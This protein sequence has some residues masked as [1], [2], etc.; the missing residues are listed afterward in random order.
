MKRAA[1]LLF[2]SLLLLLVTGF[3]TAVLARPDDTA[4]LEKWTLDD[5][6]KFMISNEQLHTAVVVNSMANHLE[7]TF[8][9]FTTSDPPALAAAK[10]RLATIEQFV[11]RTSAE[12]NIPVPTVYV[13]G[14]ATESAQTLEGQDFILV[15]K[16]K[17]RLAILADA[18]AANLK[19]TLAYQLARIRDR[20]TSASAVLSHHNDPAASREAELRAELE[21]AGPLGAHD[22]IAA[23]ITLDA[24]MRDE[25]HRLVFFKGNTLGD[26]DPNRLSD[27]DYK[28]ISDDYVRF[29]DDIYKLT[30][31]DRI[32]ALRKEAQLVN[33]YEQTH[34]VRRHADR[35][36]ESQWLVEQ[37]VKSMQCQIQRDPTILD[38]KPCGQPASR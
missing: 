10:Q 30:F 15:N 17:F 16:D 29:S 8:N 19:S 25:V 18:A 38:S 33:E 26:M 1:T 12:M 20:D 7:K 28:Q 31:W 27:R 2:Q 13:S 37:V 4:V 5:V 22:P 6:H 21:G 14:L 32:V 9:E 3:G 36:V 35:E 34:S 23:T 24:R 11:K